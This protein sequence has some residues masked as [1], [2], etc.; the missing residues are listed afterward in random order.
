V[1]LVVVLA[2]VVAVQATAYLKQQ[3][4]VATVRMVL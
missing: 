4:L 3:D 1:V 2:L